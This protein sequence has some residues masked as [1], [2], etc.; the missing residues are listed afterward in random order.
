MT[1][2]VACAA[3]P[4]AGNL[5][6]PPVRLSACPSARPVHQPARPPAGR[7]SDR[8]PAKKARMI[9]TRD[10]GGTPFRPQRGSRRHACCAEVSPGADTPTPRSDRRH[11]HDIQ[12]THGITTAPF[13]ITRE[14]RKWLRP[15]LGRY[16]SCAGR[17][18]VVCWSCTGRLLA[19]CPPRFRRAP[20]AIGAVID[21]A[22]CDRT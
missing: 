11:T 8:Q 19:V 3:Q 6:P 7:P 10:P 1:V 17:A 14:C 5:P 4:P 15:A 22:S 18:L 9:Q 20:R 16:R 13:T 12:H 2:P 21:I